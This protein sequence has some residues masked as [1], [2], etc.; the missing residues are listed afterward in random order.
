VERTLDL[1]LAHIESAVT[2]ARGLRSVSLPSL[3]DAGSEQQVKTVERKEP[4]ERVREVGRH[5]ASGGGRIGRG[6]RELIVDLG[7]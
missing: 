1:L 5:V 7:R 6:G 2:I 4:G 3:F